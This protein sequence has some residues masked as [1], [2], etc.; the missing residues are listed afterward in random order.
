M[1][2]YVNIPIHK[3]I[4]YIVDTILFFRKR[5]RSWRE[6]QDKKALFPGKVMTYLRFLPYD[7]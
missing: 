6:L 3:Y 4:I 2:K 7:T 1:H 5:A